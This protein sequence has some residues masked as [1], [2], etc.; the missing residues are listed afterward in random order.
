MNSKFRL[1]AMVLSVGLVTA[2]DP[3]P[4]VEAPVVVSTPNDDI[5]ADDLPIDEPC[6]KPNNL[7]CG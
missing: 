3:A 6:P 2:C 4:D 5:P 7:P 1:F